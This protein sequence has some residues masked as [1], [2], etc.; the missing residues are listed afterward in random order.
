MKFKRLLALPLIAM[1]LT[2]CDVRSK[3]VKFDDFKKIFD[4]KILPTKL[5]DENVKALEAS[6]RANLRDGEA[7]TSVVTSFSLKTSDSKTI[8]SE[9]KL[10]AGLELSIEYSLTNY[11]TEEGQEVEVSKESKSA[12]MKLV[13]ENDVQKLTYVASE[14]VVPADVEISEESTA[15]QKAAAVNEF[16]NMDVFQDVIADFK[17]LYN[18]YVDLLGTSVTG[19]EPKEIL[20]S[21]TNYIYRFKDAAYREYTISKSGLSIDK[22]CERASLDAKE[23]LTVNFSGFGSL[24][25]EENA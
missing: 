23:A 13:V 1:L 3:V 16:F 19:N 4:E 21:S 7:L 11:A 5:D 18:S 9:S 2:G 15:E 6:I 12:S 25:P 17:T 24:I 20:S 10:K 14:G 22:Y 8:I